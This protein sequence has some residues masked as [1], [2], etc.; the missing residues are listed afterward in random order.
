MMPCDL[1]KNPCGECP[2]CEQ[3]DQAM[4]DDFVDEIIE[5]FGDLNLTR[6]SE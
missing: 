5:L 4:H 1:I 3:H 2:D 6:V